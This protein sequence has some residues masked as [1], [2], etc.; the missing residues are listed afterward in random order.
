MV[1]RLP[2][3]IETAADRFQDQAGYAATILHG[4]HLTHPVSPSLDG[5]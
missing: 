2:N 1:P 5:G 4:A 3:S